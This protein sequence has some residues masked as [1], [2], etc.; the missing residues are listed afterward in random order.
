MTTAAIYCRK[1]QPQ[2]GVSSEAT[3]VARQEALCRAYAE[4]HGWTIDPA[5]VFTDAAISGAEFSKRPGLM[6]LLA[7]LTPATPFSE[8]IVSDSDRLGREQFETSY[9]L[10]QLS[11]AGVTVHEAKTGGRVLT[12]DSPIDKMLMSVLAGAAEIERGKARERTR[13]ALAHKA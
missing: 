4:A 10:K 12:L 2:P 7:A 8:L 9:L 1:S 3:S 11:Q 13:A 5:H 6:K